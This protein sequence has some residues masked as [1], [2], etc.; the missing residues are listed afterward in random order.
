MIKTHDTSDLEAKTCAASTDPRR[1]PATTIPSTSLSRP[2]GAWL[3]SRAR[4][5]IAALA[6]PAR[7]LAAALPIA[8]ALTTG[9]PDVFAQAA[10]LTIV[11]T[12]PHVADGV[13][14]STV[15]ITAVDVGGNPAN[16]LNLDVEISQPAF[17][18]RLGHFVLHLSPTAIGNGKY[19]VTF[20]S[21][22]EG[23]MSI[24]VTDRIALTNAR[25]GVNFTPSSFPFTR[26]VASSSASSIQPLDAAADRKS[27][28]DFFD[29]LDQEFLPSILTQRIAAEPDPAKKAVLQQRLDDL[30]QRL[31][32]PPAT[33]RG[34]LP[35]IDQ[36]IELEEKSATGVAP[37]KAETDALDAA[38]QAA[39]ASFTRISD[40]QE[41]IL[42]QFFGNP[43][44]FVKFQTC[45]ELFNNF[46]LVADFDKALERIAVSKRLRAIIND[47]SKTAAE[48]TKAAQDLRALGRLVE[49]GP[50]S[51]IAH[52]RW[53]KFANL[54]I[55]QLGVSVDLWRNLKP[56]LAKGSAITVAVLS[57]NDPVKPGIQPAK[58]SG[59]TIATIRAMFD[60]LKPKSTDTDEEKKK[61]L[62]E[63][64]KKLIEIIKA[65]RVD[66][67]VIAQL[68][69]QSG[70]SALTANIDT[71][72]CLDGG[73]NGLVSPL[74]SAI[75]LTRLGTDLFGFGVDNTGNSYTLIG[76]IFGSVA[77]FAVSGFGL[78]PLIGPAI[79]TFEGTATGDTI[80]GTWNGV[81]SSLPRNPG[82]VCVWSGSFT[83]AARAPCDID[84]NGIVDRSDVATV[85][86]ARNVR[87]AGSDNR[88]VDGD[89]VIT[90]NDARFC[91]V[92]CTNG[93]C[94]NVGGKVCTPQFLSLGTDASFVDSCSV[95]PAGSATCTPDNT[96][97][98]VGVNAHCLVAG[99]TTLTV[100][101]KDKGN[102]P[103]T[104]TITLDC[105]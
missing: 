60:P 33:T 86:A 75:N 10:S 45:T 68:P 36:D 19:V 98:I 100:M 39:K 95:A 7:A 105:K 101:F 17:V 81:G 13:D 44:D 38:A 18:N 89:G 20:A 3:R 26:L 80:V 8:I 66:R 73:E 24:V 99:T 28:E 65:I 42:K 91:T 9:S 59:P 104:K 88:D 23:P 29:K 94:A 69:G 43:V 84:G 92:S 55:T 54:M 34:V 96:R 41:Q 4:C 58:Q 83:V 97:N 22:V 32:G 14:R 64:E 35:V 12:S 49:R 53:A 77:R 15:T 102:D 48:R 90:A 63:I 31:P 30:F 51:S 67:K 72:S 57:D 40:T 87:V 27:C 1:H 61:K 62:Q 11:A 16:F 47:P 85:L 78:N 70:S 82:N 6:G 103:Q 52:V 56:I 37:T 46:D 5:A 71:A 50:D 76:T 93:I 2:S 79:A 25:S 21:P 74:F